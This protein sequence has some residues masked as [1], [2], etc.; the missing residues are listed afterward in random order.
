M[1]AYQRLR[2]LC[3]SPTKRFY[4][5]ANENH[6]D[7]FVKGLP[8]ESPNDRN[9]RAIRMAAKWWVWGRGGGGCQGEPQGHLCQGAAGGEL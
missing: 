2:A 8:G 5:F 4:V 6:K 3:A 7:T 1:S 9:D